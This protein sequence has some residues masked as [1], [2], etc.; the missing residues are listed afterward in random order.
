MKKE[1]AMPK[2]AGNLSRKKKPQVAQPGDMN[3]LECLRN[4]KKHSVTRAQ[5]QRGRAVGDVGGEGGSTVSV[6]PGNSHFMSMATQS[7]RRVRGRE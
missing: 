6:G 7:H 3:E 2:L 4:T 5:Q 1:P